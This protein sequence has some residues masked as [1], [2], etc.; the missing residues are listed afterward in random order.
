VLKCGGEKALTKQV[1][2][3]DEAALRLQVPVDEACKVSSSVTDV[4][5]KNALAIC[6]A[7]V[8]PAGKVKP[9]VTVVKTGINTVKSRLGK[10]MHKL[11][12]LEPGNEPEKPLNV[13]LGVNLYQM[14]DY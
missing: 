5:G 1:H 9:K 7:Q 12:D 13:D 8:S 14:E 3:P 2:V 11:Y 6:G 4:M 10:I